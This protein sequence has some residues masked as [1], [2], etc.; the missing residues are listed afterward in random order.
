MTVRSTTYGYEQSSEAG[1]ERHVKIP[2]ARLKDT[3]PTIG[4]PACVTSVI[5]GMEITGTVI[6][7]NATNEE[8]IINFSEG[9]IYRHNV[10]NV[11]TYN[12]V[13]PP[14]TEAT[15]GLINI[16]DPVFYD[17]MADT[18]TAGVCKLSTAPFEAGVPAVPNPRFGTIVM[19]QDEDADDFGAEGKGSAQEG[20]SDVYGV[21]Q[22][23]LNDTY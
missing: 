20:V 10:R 2:Y 7:I 11:L 6:T 3:T 16:G 9:A 1:R 18:N 12:D 14:Q 4:D 8:A 23:G 19:M 17:E 22:A 15:W 5:V 21:L 13:G